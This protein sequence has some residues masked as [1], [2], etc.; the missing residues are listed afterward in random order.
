MLC[1]ILSGEHK[2]KIGIQLPLFVDNGKREIR[3][4]SG[5]VISVEQ[6]LICPVGA[7]NEFHAKAGK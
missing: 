6:N 2:G 3:L 1:V 5:A 4:L 7:G